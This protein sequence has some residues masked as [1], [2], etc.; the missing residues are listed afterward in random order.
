MLSSFA[1]HTTPTGLL[2]VVLVVG[3]HVVAVCVSV[4]A[5]SVTHSFVS[6]TYS[7]FVMSHGNVAADNVGAA[8]VVRVILLIL[9]L[10]IVSVM[11]SAVT[12]VVVV[13]GIVNPTHPF[14]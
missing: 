9:Q 11:E 8:P 5:Q 2:P 14:L 13:P 12:V 4:A 1:L 3:V 6:F 7:F 10:S